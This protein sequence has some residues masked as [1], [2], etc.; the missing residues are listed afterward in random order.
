MVLSKTSTAPVA[1]DPPRA[2]PAPSCCHFVSPPQDPSK[3]K[4]KSL[5]VS[6]M[7]AQREVDID[8][9][10]LFFPLGGFSLYPLEIVQSLHKII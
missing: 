9:S 1:A 10:H 2:Q 3:F 5:E 7:T 8:W 6:R 4:I